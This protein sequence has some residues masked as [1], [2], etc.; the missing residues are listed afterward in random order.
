MEVLTFVSRDL[1]G[2]L[3]VI[4]VIRVLLE[5][6]QRFIRDILWILCWFYS[7]ITR[8]YSGFIRGSL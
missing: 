4:R 2:L 7:E 1:W 5:F 3:G 8:A 6:F